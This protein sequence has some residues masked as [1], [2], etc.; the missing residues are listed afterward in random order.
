MSRSVLLFSL[1]LLEAC[2]SSG[3]PQVIYLARHGQTGYNRVGRFQGDPDLDSVGY[4]N[5]V[6][7]WNLL[8]ERPIAAVYTSDRL[9]TRRTAEL[10]ARQHALPVQ[11]RPALNEIHGGVLEGICFSQMAPEKSHPGDRGCEVRSRGAQIE[12]VLPLLRRIYA[13]ASRDPIGGKFP[14]AESLSDVAKRV[15]GF[16]D[17]LRRGFAEREVLVVGH[18]VV[19][20]V[21]L[22]H[23]MGWP[24]E[25]VARLRQQND[26]IYRIE[27]DGE[28]VVRLSLYSPGVGWRACQSAPSSESHQ[29][30]CHPPRREP[31]VPPASQPASRPR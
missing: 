9:R 15:G 18:G 14:L 1:L 3:T 30:D 16:V 25:S 20:R 23:L 8:K 2:A 11:S 5:R 13:E 31:A 28:K 6:G 4:I 7:L 27:T 17:E 29:L 24:L 26:Q 10:V 12:H 21:I 22:H 19:N